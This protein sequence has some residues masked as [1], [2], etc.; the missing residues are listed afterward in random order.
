MVAETM[1]ELPDAPRKDIGDGIVIV[2]GPGG[3]PY[4]TS[5]EQPHLGGNFNGG[6][7]GT[8]YPDD[9]W[10]WLVRRFEVKSMLDIGCGTGETAQWFQYQGVKALGLDGLAWNAKRANVPCIVWDLT[11]GPLCVEGI[12]LIWCADV[13]EHIEEEFVNNLLQTVRSCKVL[14]FC[15]GTEETLNSGWHHVNNKPESYWVEKLRDVGMVESV[16][17]TA[18]SRELGNH[19]WWSIS[20]RIYTRKL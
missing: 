5:P 16:N 10:P 12:D 18:H 19:G 2:S 14:A 13:A 11:K 7:L 8:M 6:D 4:I 3:C 1:I 17:E 9:L 20:G 15:H